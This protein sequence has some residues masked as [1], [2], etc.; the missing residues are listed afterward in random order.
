MRRWVLIL[1]LAVA[2][3]VLAGEEPVAQAP[4]PQQPAGRTPMPT[5]AKGKGDSCVAP[6]EWMRRNHMKALVHQR[7]ATVHEGLRGAKFSLKDCVSCHVVPDSQGRAVP[8]SDPKHFCRSCHDYAAVS[9]DCFECHASR[10][11][12]A[13]KGAQLG[14]SSAH[15]I[16]ALVQYLEGK[17]P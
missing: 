4:S 10:P 11:E 3:P 13:A 17:A 15:D 6:V 1:M 9:I 12:E 5:P 8:V 7:N 16:A 2:G 14:A